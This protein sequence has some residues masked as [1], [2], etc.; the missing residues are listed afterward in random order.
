M[1]HYFRK[2]RVTLSE[3]VVT[4][5]GWDVFS[6][7][8]Q[9]V[10]RKFYHRSPRS[11]CLIFPKNL[12]THVETKTQPASETEKELERLRNENNEL[13]A[14][15]SELE[16]FKRTVAQV[17]GMLRALNKELSQA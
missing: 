10:A 13:R 2:S 3:L 15:V 14:K 16:R 5:L 12:K 1:V 8:S 4:W 7:A 11:E 9:P 6:R 17:G